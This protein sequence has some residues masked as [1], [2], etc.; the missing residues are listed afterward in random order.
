MIIGGQGAD[1]PNSV[2]P[3][4]LLPRTDD[5]P[6]GVPITWHLMRPA[7]GLRATDHEVEVRGGQVEAGGSRAEELHC[8]DRADALLRVLPRNSLPRSAARGC[9]RHRALAPA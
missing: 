6:S 7:R 3:V 1:K 2:Y 4:S 5:H 9:L 8:N